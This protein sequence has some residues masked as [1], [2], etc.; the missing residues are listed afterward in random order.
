MQV[1]SKRS[2]STFSS[3]ER[4][5]QMNED[6][7]ALTADQ[8]ETDADAVIDTGVDY[9]PETRDDARGKHTSRVVPA[10]LV[11][12]LIGVGVLG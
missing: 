8:N 7:P 12:C 10:L 9:P 4:D 3:E 11:L 1:C 6:K 5:K 2:S